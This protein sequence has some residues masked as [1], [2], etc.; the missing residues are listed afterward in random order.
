[1][2]TANNAILDSTKSL[3]GAWRKI[4]NW[5]GMSVNVV[6]LEHGVGRVERLD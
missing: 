1:M 2:Q 3:D 5:T 4:D 6:G